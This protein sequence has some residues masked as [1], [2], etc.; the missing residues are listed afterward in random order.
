MKTEKKSYLLSIKITMTHFI[1]SVLG[2]L[3][4]TN[5]YLLRNLPLLLL[6]L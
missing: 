1:Q 6:S 2:E 5:K 4:F 3:L